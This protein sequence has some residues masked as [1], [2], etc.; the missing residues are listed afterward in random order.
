M[1]PDT[2]S[3]LD[4]TLHS[5]KFWGLVT[6]LVTAACSYFFAHTDPTMTLLGVVSLLSFYFVGTGI[7]EHGRMMAIGTALQ[8]PPIATATVNEAPKEG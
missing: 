3:K 6:G 2:Y 7:E 4:A 1:P 8:R 5:R